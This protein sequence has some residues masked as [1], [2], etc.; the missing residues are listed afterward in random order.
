MAIIS[1]K[2]SQMWYKDGSIAFPSLH[3]EG[4]KSSWLCQC[5]NQKVWL[6]SRDLL[7][8]ILTAASK[9]P[10][11]MWL[12]SQG[13]GARSQS[14]QSPCGCPVSPPSRSGTSL[15][16]GIAPPSCSED[17][18]RISKADAV[19]DLIKW[20]ADA[21]LILSGSCCRWHSLSLYSDFPQ[22]YREKI[23]T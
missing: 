6:A 23:P 2:G 7:K 9:V 15:W 18:T 14:S 3:H 20:I 1:D 16:A 4:H 21:R 11:L 22:A 8:F 19:T 13:R 10:V 12:Q 5:G 17:L